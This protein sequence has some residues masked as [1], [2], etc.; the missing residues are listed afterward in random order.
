[1]NK[2]QHFTSL[3]SLRGFAALFVVFLHSYWSHDFYFLNFIRNSYLFVD[4]FFIL[5][6]FVIIY[7]YHDKLLYNTISIKQ[8]VLKRFYRLWPLHFSILLV[9]LFLEFTKFIF[10]TYFGISGTN[11]PFS[12]NNGIAFFANLFFFQSFNTFQDATFNGPSWSISVEFFTYIF[13]AV[14]IIMFKNKINLYKYFSLIV[15][16]TSS[17]FLY[18]EI[19]HL[20]VTHD[21]GFIRCLFGFFSGIII[22]YLYNSSLNFYSRIK[23]IN[24]FTWTIIELFT[25]FFLIYSLSWKDEVNRLDFISFALFFIIIYLFI[26][27]KGLVS[28]LLNYRLFT[29]LGKISFSIYMV[30]YFYSILLN[31]FL[32][33]YYK[34]PFIVDKW[35][36]YVEINPMVGN[37]YLIFYLII[38]IISAHYTYEFIEQRYRYGFFKKKS[39]NK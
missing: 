32:K 27:S 3:D 7:N 29:Y 22:F 9:F 39:F 4:L 15:I 23:N 38:V 6:G 36:G 12:E 8:F 10:S 14:S 19:G 20:S 26:F 18:F 33:I 11:I 35:G 5:S 13:F 31:N 21:F 24:Y 1:M 34:A 16:I 2:K 28:K 17:Y 37:I 25:I 30:H